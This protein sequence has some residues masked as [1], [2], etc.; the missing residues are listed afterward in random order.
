MNIRRG[1]Y[2]RS[3]TQNSSDV[4]ASQRATRSRKLAKAAVAEVRENRRKELE[5]ALLR[6]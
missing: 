6:P 2:A 1:H 3:K 4:S 5:A